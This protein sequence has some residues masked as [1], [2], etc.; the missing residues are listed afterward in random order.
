[1]ANEVNAPKTP[2]AVG[3]ADRTPTIRPHWADQGDEVQIHWRIPGEP[4]F[5]QKVTCPPKS[6]RISK[7]SAVA[8]P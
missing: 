1:M 8:E 6:T 4:I 7:G 3:C 5:V 2:S